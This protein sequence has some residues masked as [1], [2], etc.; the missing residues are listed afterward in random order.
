MR[1]LLLSLLLGCAS[2]KPAICANQDTAG[3]VAEVA[4]KDSPAKTKLGLSIARFV[5][6]WWCSQ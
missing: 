1:P 6:N 5:L 4:T 2:V 3:E